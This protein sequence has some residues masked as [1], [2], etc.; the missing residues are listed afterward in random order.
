MPKYTHRKV[1]DLYE[2]QTEKTLRDRI[3]PILDVLAGVMV[4]LVILAAAFG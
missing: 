4:V 1:A 2:I 3:K